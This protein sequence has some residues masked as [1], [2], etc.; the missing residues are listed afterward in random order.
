MDL[1]ALRYFVAVSEELHFGR[2]AQRLHMAQPP[3]SQQIRKLEQELGVQLLHR[4]KRTVS[5]TK[6]GEYLL[7]AAQVILKQVETAATGVRAAGQ[8]LLG[9]LSIGLIN[10]VSYQ[11]Q[12]FEVLHEFRRNH[13]G[14]A[15]TLK[16]MTSVEQLTALREGKIHL[17]FLRAPL[18]DKTIRSEVVMTEELL[19]ALPRDHRL[20]PLDA[21]VRLKDLSQDAFVMLPRSE[22]FGLSEQIMKLCQRAGF[23]PRIAQH[24]SELPTLCGLVAAGFGVA[25]IPSSALILPFYGAVYKSLHSR[26]TVTTVAAYN[27]TERFPALDA[28][29]QI[30]RNHP[31]IASTRSCPLK[32]R[33]PNGYGAAAAADAVATAAAAG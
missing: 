27:A 22:G 4:T 18:R 30:T 12:I 26:E 1:R 10:A 19:V 21:S 6:P 14:V 17:G 13:P 16:V 31:A 9:Q 32:V 3:L 7:E 24:A 25:L 29:L 20:A 11:G 28:F 15:V 8:G 2:A 23:T 5:L 33:S